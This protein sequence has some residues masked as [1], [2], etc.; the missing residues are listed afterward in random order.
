MYDTSRLPQTPVY[1]ALAGLRGRAKEV[2]LVASFLVALAP[3]AAMAQRAPTSLPRTA[4][5]VSPSTSEAQQQPS[6]SE[7]PLPTRGNAPTTAGLAKPQSGGQS[8]SGSYVL[9]GKD[10]PPVYG[11]SQYG[12]EFQDPD[13]EAARAFA[14]EYEQKQRERK[15][16]LNRRLDNLNSF[17][18]GENTTMTPR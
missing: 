14:E 7:A 8:G 1:H 11:G 13:Q 3:A 9:E 4:P 16:E 17:S 2:A 12:S 15:I 18:G 6:P 10:L 5:D